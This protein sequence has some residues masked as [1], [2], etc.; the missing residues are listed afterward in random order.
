MRAKE[1]LKSMGAE[2]EVYE[3]DLREDAEALQSVLKDLSG[4]TTV[5]PL[6]TPR[7]TLRHRYMTDTFHLCIL[8]SYDI[9]SREAN[10]WL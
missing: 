6:R 9:C 2:F 4:H 10:R 1:L 3:V 5:S 7:Q 8:V